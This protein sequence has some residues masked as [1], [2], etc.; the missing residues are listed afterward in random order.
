MRA[1]FGSLVVLCTVGACDKETPTSKADSKADAKADANGPIGAFSKYKAKSMASEAKINLPSIST[2]VRIAF[3]EERAEP[4][5]LTVVTGQLP[6]STPMT[7]AAGAC[8]KEP[9]GTC[10]PDMGDWNQEGWKTVGFTPG[11]PHRYSYEIITKDQTVTI[12][13]QGDLDCDGVL[14]TYEMVGTVVDGSLEFSP[15]LTETDPLE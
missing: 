4:G 11:N 7:P 9:D 8:C 3:E 2:G 15:A 6:S 13:A 12:R 10:A 1:W 14:S 5:S